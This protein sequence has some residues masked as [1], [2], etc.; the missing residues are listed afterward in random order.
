MRKII[1]SLFCLLLA[2]PAWADEWGGGLS[3]YHHSDCDKILP[4]ILALFVLLLAAGA[5]TAVMHMFKY[6]GKKT[7]ALF[8]WF[9]LF[10]YACVC[11]DFWSHVRSLLGT[12]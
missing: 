4:V 12:F 2:A 10:Y 7:V 8:L 6:R 11:A 1:T 3:V 5:A 9:E